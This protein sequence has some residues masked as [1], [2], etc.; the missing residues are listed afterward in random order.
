MSSRRGAKPRGNP[1]VADATKSHFQIM[2]Y[3]SKKARW[4]PDGESFRQLHLVSGEPHDDDLNEAFRYRC[5]CEHDCC[6]HVQTSIT[7][8][9]LLKSGDLAVIVSGWR[10]I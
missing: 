10:N 7:K 1:A 4:T 6:G 2:K 8:T 3:T 9:R 5:G